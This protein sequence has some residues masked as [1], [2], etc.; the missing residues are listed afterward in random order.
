M[1]R[2]LIY[3]AAAAAC[4]IAGGAVIARTMHIGFGHGVYCALGTAATVG[5]DATPA[6]AGA[7][8]A[9]AAVIVVCIP[10]FALAYGSLS[11]AHVRKHMGLHRQA[12]VAQLRAELDDVRA[13]VTTSLD[14]A[15]SALHRKLDDH[16][17]LV[18]SAVQQAAAMQ[19][20]APAAPEPPADKPKPAAAKTAAS[21]TPPAPK[22]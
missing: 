8:L 1:K 3:M 11:S 5:C 4:I 15:T 20:P 7:R 14:N 18:N 19:P 16:A 2:A 12:A 17:E 10:L 22:M 21:R 9:S 13:H 6:D